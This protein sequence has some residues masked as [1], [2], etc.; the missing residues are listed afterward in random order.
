MQKPKYGVTRIS[1]ISV[2]LMLVVV[3]IACD[4]AE[5]AARPNIVFIAVDDLR[6]ELGCYGADYVVSPNIDRLASQGLVFERAYCQSAVC[7]PSRA[8]LMTGKRPD[9]LHVW[10]LRSDMRT[11]NPEVVTLGQHLQTYG[12][13]SVGIGKIFHNT[14]PD[15]ATWSEPKLH[16]EGYPFDPDAV[17]RG[18][19]GIRGQEEKKAKI[20]EAGDEARAIDQF[21]QWYLKAQATECVDVPDSAYFDGAQTDVVIDKLVE[22]KELDQPFFFAVGYYRPHLP[23][24]APKKYWDL[25]DREN[26][27]LPDNPNLPEEIPEMAIN[28]LRELRGYTDFKDIVHP[29]EGTLDEDR[30]R[31]L[32]HGYFASVS[33]VDAQ[34]GKL[35]RALEDLGLDQNTIVVLWGDHGW[36]LGEHNSW[37]KMTNLE[38]DARVPLILRVPGMSDGGS[39]TEALV[40]FVDIYPTLCDLAGIPVPDDL[41][42]RSF[43]PLVADPTRPWKTAAF[44]QF[45][46]EGIWI[47]PDGVEYM[48]Y[49]VR[50]DRYRYTEWLNWETKELAATELYDHQ[51]DPLETRNVA[52]KPDYAD[53]RVEMA[54]VL[55]AGWQAALPEQR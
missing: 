36:K 47:A 29:T 6:P 35:M 17:Y 48:G 12:Y 16:I 9:S 37:C 41:E 32:R 43:G 34:V 22:L 3:S 4:S 25:Y 13:H 40:E 55:D 11:L 54:A 14:L 50:T 1:L 27:P 19:E 20:I 5:T 53:A 24:N 44:T 45:L 2:C 46:R 33:Y 7:N 51:R 52:D 26:I 42:G 18:Q 28:N 23:F 30:T 21:G 31:L 8:S 10:D 38:I 49:S 39:R 15:P